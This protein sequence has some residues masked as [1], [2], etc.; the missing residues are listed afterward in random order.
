MTR[1]H[2]ADDASQQGCTDVGSIRCRSRLN[3][4]PCRQIASRRDNLY[5]HDGDKYLLHAYCIMPNRVHAVLTPSPGEIGNSS[6]LEP[7]TVGETTDRGS[8]LSGIM[9]S[10]KSYTANQANATLNRSGAFWQVESY[11]HWVRDDDD[12][13][14]IVNY[15]RAN[16]VA[17]GLVECHQ[18]WF[19]SSCHDRYL[20]DGDTSAWLRSTP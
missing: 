4:N 15:V 16:P 3:G 2:V 7:E 20:C 13:E 10:L 9:H 17:A 14:R 1:V 18:D 5:Y 8:P 19:W 6:H 11:D 12:L